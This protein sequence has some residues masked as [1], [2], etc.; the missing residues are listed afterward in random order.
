MTSGR[1]TTIVWQG[2][3]ASCIRLARSFDQCSHSYVGGDLRVRGA[4][5]GESNGFVVATGKA[6]QER[7]QDRVGRGRRTRAA[8]GTTS[9]TKSAVADASGPVGPRTGCADSEPD[10][11]PF[12]GLCSRKRRGVS[13]IP[14]RTRTCDPRFRNPGLTSTPA[15]SPTSRPSQAAAGVPRR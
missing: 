15:S 7:H 2:T 14:G 6:A 3:L 5:C 11:A 8:S 13:G 9:G 12:P 4:P 1:S 10:Q